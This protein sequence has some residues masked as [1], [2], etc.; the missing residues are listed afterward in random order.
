MKLDT[1][2]ERY[3]ILEGLIKKSFKLD[4]MW[5]H[6]EENFNDWASNMEIAD[7]LIA[8]QKL[9]YAEKIFLDVFDETE[10]VRTH[11]F[12]EQEIF[13]NIIYE[14]VT[15][16]VDEILLQLIEYTFDNL[17]DWQFKTDVGKK[18]HKD[19]SKKLDALIKKYQDLYDL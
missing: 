5:V 17:N 11:N 7:K 12:E 8:I 13:L 16:F 1:S 3:K 19:V 15:R 14:N 6:D 4:K 9:I 10:N 18:F 2:W